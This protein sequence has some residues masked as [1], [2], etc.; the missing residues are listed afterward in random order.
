MGDVRRIDGPKPRSITPASPVDDMAR[1]VALLHAISADVDAV[2]DSEVERDADRI[3]L[4]QSH[5]G[6]IAD[7][8]R[9]GHKDIDEEW[10]RLLAAV[11]A[12]REAIERGRAR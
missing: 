6:E 8:Y 11:W 5:L 1:R 10:T 2:S 12:V 9:F 3:A 7:A 4:V